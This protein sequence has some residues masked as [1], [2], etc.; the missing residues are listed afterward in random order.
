MKRPIQVEKNRLVWLGHHPLLRQLLHL[1]LM[2]AM[3]QVNQMALILSL[4]LFW[5]RTTTALMGRMVP[6]H[7]PQRIAPGLSRLLI[8][9]VPPSSPIQAIPGMQVG[10]VLPRRRRAPVA[11][12]IKGIFFPFAFLF[13]LV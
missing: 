6:I 7:R 10:T 8:V 3:N 2:Y 13:A 11:Q 4:I 1:R 9:Q 12:P 5:C